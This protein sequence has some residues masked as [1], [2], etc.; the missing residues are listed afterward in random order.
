MKKTWR[1]H[2]VDADYNALA[3]RYGIEPLTA[4][5]IKNRNVPDD[6]IG[7]Y[8]HP[9]RD[10]IHDPHVLKDGMLAA[11]IMMDAIHARQKIRII[12]DYDIDGIMSTY[13]LYSAITRVGGDVDYRV[14][15]RIEDGYGLNPKLVEEAND[16]GIDLIITCD[17]GI[18]AVDAVREAKELGM[19]VI[20]TDHHAI[21]YDDAGNEKLP[22]ADAIVNPHLKDDPST[23]KEICGACVAWKYMFLLYELAGLDV[24][25][26][27]EFLPY[28]A[29]ATVGD[30]MPLT[31]ENRAIVKLGITALKLT[32]NVGLQ[33]L[34]K[35]TST[36]PERI[37]SYRIGF[38]LGPCLNA[39]GR[40]STAK[41]GV[42]L[43]LEQDPSKAKEIA[44]ELVQL[45][46]ERKDITQSGTD[47]A[48]IMAEEAPYVDDNVLVL[49]LPEIPES[50]VGIVAGRVREHTAKPAIVLT[51]SEANH[52]VAKGS[53]RSI[54]AYRMNEKLHEAESLLIGYGGHP[55]AA[56][57]SLPV[58]DVDTLR[59]FLNEHSGLTEEDIVDE[60]M[61]DADMPF[62]Y[63]LQ[64][65]ALIDE[66]K[67]IEP[68]G[69]E[70]EKP[71]FADKQIKIRRLQKIGK[72]SQFLK[73]SLEDRYGGRV[74]AVYFRDSVTFLDDLKN[75]YGAKAV[76]DAFRGKENPMELAVSYYP[77]WNEYR[78]MVSVQV[79][80]TGY[81]LG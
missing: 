23:Y 32:Q 8:L 62:T 59:I 2:P 10:D 46:E 77:D 41:L 21:P 80:V 72:E 15:H 40:M 53:A 66:L 75:K 81:H 47:N 76:E 36:P 60:L 28:A 48:Y 37:D 56:G 39:S 30:V 74:D 61:I 18:S 54:P 52:E 14:P 63:L 17:N 3:T 11:E 70:N 12:G 25:L 24:D 1:V 71:V 9:T 19:T 22:I 7:T 44:E 73:L 4:R 50:I 42:E 57:L 64:H 38:V 35:A 69:N 67:T 31:G 55:M 29:F 65:T 68:F 43:L 26:A 34:Y 5:L 33:A 78:G 16:A 27:W 20:I 79:V 49:F 13:I 58:G 6:E 45:N 51:V